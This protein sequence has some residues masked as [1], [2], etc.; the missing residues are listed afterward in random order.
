MPFQTPHHVPL[1]VSDD[2]PAVGGIEGYDAPVIFSSNENPNGRENYSLPNRHSSP[3]FTSIM[4]E[5]SEKVNFVPPSV[6]DSEEI[7][8]SSSVVENVPTRCSSAVDIASV[9]LNARRNFN[10]SSPVPRDVKDAPRRAG[11]VFKRLIA[12]LTYPEAKVTYEG[13][14][15]EAYYDKEKKRWIFPGEENEPEPEPLA[16]PPTTHLEKS[17]S[18]EIKPVKYDPLAALMAPPDPLALLMVPPTHSFGT[19]RGGYG[20]GDSNSQELKGHR[21]RQAPPVYAVF[22]PVQATT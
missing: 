22:T 13:K 21:S 8:A 14:K 6:Q 1:D 19:D 16:P 4:L 18:D 12:R 10:S 17:A 2:H 3:Q 7:S 11:S 5:K 9:A 15:M 20:V